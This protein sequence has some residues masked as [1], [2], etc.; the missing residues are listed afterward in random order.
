MIRYRYAYQ[1]SIM[2]RLRQGSFWRIARC[3]CGVC[4]ASLYLKLF[5][6]ERLVEQMDASHDIWTCDICLRREMARRYRIV[7]AFC[8]GVR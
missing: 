2:R 4:A 8:G 1:K 6:P 5:E 7:Q 3:Q